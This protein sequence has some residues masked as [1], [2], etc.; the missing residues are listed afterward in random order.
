MLIESELRVNRDTE[1]R[2]RKKRLVLIVEDN[3]LLKGHGAETFAAKDGR[4]A[5]DKCLEAGMNGHMSKPIDMAELT[6]GLAKIKK[7]A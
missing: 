2:V 3:E 4:E 5:V 6:A 7:K 1:L